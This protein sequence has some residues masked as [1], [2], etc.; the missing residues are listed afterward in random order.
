MAPLTFCCAPERPQFVVRKN[1][2]ARRAAGSLHGPCRVRWGCGSRRRDW[3]A[4]SSGGATTAS[5]WS[6][7]RR[8]AVV[9]DAVEQAD[10]FRPLDAVNWPCAEPRE[11]VAI[12]YCAALVD[13]A[14]VLALTLKELFRH[15]PQRVGRR[16][17]AWPVVR[18]A[19][20]APSLRHQALSALAC[21]PR[22][23]TACR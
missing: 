9:L 18:R 19:D 7:R 13:R 15:G 12:K 1:A 3:R 23:R 2:V 6:R 14:Q 5:T 20:R 22:R 4:N 17:Y 10:D 8:A 21:A 16:A 11:D